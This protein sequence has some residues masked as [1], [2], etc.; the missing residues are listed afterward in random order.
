MARSALFSLSSAGA[1]VL[2]SSRSRQHKVTI[3]GN[4]IEAHSSKWE[5]KQ[6]NKEGSMKFSSDVGP[7][8]HSVLGRF[9]APVTVLKDAG[10]NLILSERELSG[11]DCT[12][13]GCTRLGQNWTVATY[14]Y[15]SCKFCPFIHMDASG[16][17]FLKFH[18]VGL[19]QV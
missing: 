9:M 11:H 5:A 19:P 13:R 10:V 14:L 2:L 6:A 7:D 16:V 1:D 3:V 12:L 17:T 18:L 4:A 15:C 8:G